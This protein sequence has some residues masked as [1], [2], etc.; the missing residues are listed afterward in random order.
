MTSGAPLYNDLNPWFKSLLGWITP[1]QVTTVST[2]GVYRVYRFDHPDAKGTLALKVVK[3]DTRD[4]WIGF[5][6]GIPWASSLQHGAYVFWGYKNGNLHSDLLD[7]G[8]P[9]SQGTE[10]GLRVGATF[11]DPIAG[12]VIRTESEGGESPHEYLDMKISFAPKI[13][14]LSMAKVRTPG[15]EIRKESPSG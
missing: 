13:L 10:P 11:V 1:D 15:F 14:T 9:A 5:R 8:G 3:D 6:R 12:I 2:S 7:M 4:Y